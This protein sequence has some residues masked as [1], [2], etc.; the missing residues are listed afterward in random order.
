M[1]SDNLPFISFVVLCYNTERY[2]GECIRSIL[3]QEGPY[4]FEIIA[5]EDCSPDGTRDALRAISDP[6][7]R[8]IEHQ[9]NTGHI[10]AINEALVATRGDYVARI[11]SDDR[12]RPHFL[13]ETVPKLEQFPDVGMV[14]G[15][16]AIIDHN[17]VQGTAACDRRHGGKDFKGQELIPL[18]MDN[19]VCAPTVIARREAW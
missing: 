5:V 16:A 12:Y 9:R 7:L 17:G 15:N 14:Y 10:A 6:R 13:M 4:E 3:S 1:R 18:L 2:V 8:V 19:F 11:D